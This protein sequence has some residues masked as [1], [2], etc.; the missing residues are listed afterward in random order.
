MQ[1]QPCWGC[2][3]SMYA[4]A[5]SGDAET[6]DNVDLSKEDESDNGKKRSFDSRI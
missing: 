1:R 4:H 5:P 2:I 3:R 6:A